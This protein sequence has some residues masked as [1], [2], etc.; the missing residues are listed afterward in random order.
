MFQFPG[1]A[2]FRVIYLTIDR[3]APFGNLGIIACVLL[4]QAYRSLPRPS[5][6]LCAKASTVRRTLLDP[7]VLESQLSPDSFGAM[8]LDTLLPITSVNCQRARS[9][10]RERKS[11]SA[12][13]QE[14]FRHRGQA[15]G[16]SV[17]QKGGDPAAGSP[18]ATLLR[19]RPSH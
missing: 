7:I 14:T 13:R 9:N 3:V 10:R 4:P 2:P 8:I 17:F 15:A 1:F 19:L 18:T 12:V 16:Y 5:S 11:K 6:P